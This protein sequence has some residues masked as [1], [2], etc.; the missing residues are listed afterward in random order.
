MLSQTVPDHS[1]RLYTLSQT[2]QITGAQNLIF[3]S[4]HEALDHAQALLRAHFGVELWQTH[5]MV[6]IV[7]RRPALVSD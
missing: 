7:E 1:Y 6:G 3:D 2:G 4:D 5:R